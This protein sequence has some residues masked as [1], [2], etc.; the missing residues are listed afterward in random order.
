[1]NRKQIKI[2]FNIG[3]EMWPRITGC[4]LTFTSLKLKMSV[5]NVEL[6]TEG[7]FFTLGNIMP[8]FLDAGLLLLTLNALDGIVF[9]CT[10]FWALLDVD[11]V[12]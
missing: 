8:P 7:L 10:V 12:V 9:D 6:P 1:M 3:N 2:Q 5:V 11:V 4:W